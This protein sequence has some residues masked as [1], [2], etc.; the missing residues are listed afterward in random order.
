MKA[1]IVMLILCRNEADIICENLSYH[2]RHG[3]D[4]FVIM[5]NGSID[6]T[7]DLVAEFEK[8]GVATIVDQPM[9]IK[10]QGKWMTELAGIALDKYQPDWIIASDVDE[11]WIPDNGN[12]LTTMQQNA[13]GNKHGWCTVQRF[14]MLLSQKQLKNAGRFWQINLCAHHPFSYPPEYIGISKP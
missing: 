3:V 8:L 12:I 1:S 13:L 7:R 9:H 14:N 4:A 10:A 2:L 11:F 5:D 6:G